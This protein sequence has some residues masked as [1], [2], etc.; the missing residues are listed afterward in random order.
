M[1][2]NVEQADSAV[3]DF[4]MNRREE[5][6]HSDLARAN[7]LRLRGEFPEAERLCLSV[8]DR[9]PESAA[10]H[11]LLGDVAFSQDKMA[12]AIQHYEIAQ[13]LDPHAPDIPRKLKEARVL[14]QVRETASTE[15]QLGLPPT[16]S[17]PWTPILFGSLAV[18]SLIGAAL[19]GI[20][21][22][23]PRDAKKGPSVAA[24]I[25]A[26]TETL[27]T[28]SPTTPPV[29]AKPK[30]ETVAPTPSPAPSTVAAGLPLEDRTLFQLLQQR[31]QEGSRLIEVAQDPRTKMVALTYSVG[32]E[33]D[34]RSIGAELA[35]TTLEQSNETLIVTLRAVRD[36]RLVY[37]ADVPRTRYA[38]T[39]TDEWQRNNQTPGAWT[40]YV[41]T[42]EWPFRSPDA[43]ATPV[44]TP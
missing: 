5:E 28:S 15:E 22:S 44:K 42:N 41:M 3:R 43:S 2:Q 1:R 32:A 26:T 16:R 39:L 8:L 11:T 23:S 34:A 24:P 31:S 35:R 4:E 27:A 29:D 18:L 21:A 19:A 14:T 25:S 40:A 10:A 6:L 20:S 33:D 36:E 30:A 17:L 12:E 13:G 38:D 37:V 9:F 7:L